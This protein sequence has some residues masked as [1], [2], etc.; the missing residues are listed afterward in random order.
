MQYGIVYYAT[1]EKKVYLASMKFDAR[2]KRGQKRY[3]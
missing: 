2:T 1:R 3:E